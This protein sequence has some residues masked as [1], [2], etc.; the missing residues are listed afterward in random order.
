MLAGAAAGQVSAATWIVAVAAVAWAVERTIRHRDLRAQHDA[1]RTAAE[2]EAEAE[3]VRTTST[4]AAKPRAGRSTAA[5]RPGRRARAGTRPA[6]TSTPSPSRTP[7]RVLQR[8]VPFVVPP[9]SQQQDGGDAHA[10][11]QLWDDAG[12]F[13][14]LREDRAGTAGRHGQAQRSGRTQA[15]EPPTTAP[16]RYAVDPDAAEP[17]ARPRR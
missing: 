4:A 9:H 12:H 2:A 7:D 15:A 11:E 3:A 5:Q 17:A 13:H 6:G 1:I 8:S 14:C 10:P 16:P